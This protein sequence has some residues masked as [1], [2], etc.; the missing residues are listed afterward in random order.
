MRT[1]G[2]AALP[3]LPPGASVSAG[4]WAEFKPP[5][6][7]GHGDGAD[8]KAA[9]LHRTYLTADGRKAS[10]PK[11]RKC[12]PGL[13]LPNGS[14]V[15]LADVTHDVLGV[16]EGIETALSASA[17]WGIPVWAAI[18]ARGMQAWSPPEGVQRVFVFGDCDASFA[19]QEAAYGL[20]K[21]LA[22]SRLEVTVHIPSEPG[23]TGMIST[24]GAS[25]LEVELRRDETLTFTVTSTAHTQAPSRAL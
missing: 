16:A 11:A 21:R 4:Q 18:C 9:T 13:G 24:A 8:G 19:G 3:T 17:L 10:V 15:R 25:P 5:G 2:G 7:V 22:L 20:A 14:A 6:D 23:R 12:L 1:D